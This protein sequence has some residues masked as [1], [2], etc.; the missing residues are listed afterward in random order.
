MA[1]FVLITP[2]SIEATVD[3]SFSLGLDAAAMLAGSSAQS[4]RLTA[5][6]RGAFVTEE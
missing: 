2:A 6:A 5:A 4:L 3:A 1:A